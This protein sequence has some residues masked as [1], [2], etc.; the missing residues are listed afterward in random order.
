MK[1]YHK[2]AFASLPEDEHL[3]VRNISKTIKSKQIFNEI[4][5]ALLVLITYVYHKAQFEKRKV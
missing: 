1:K 3:D 4:L 2:L 5:C